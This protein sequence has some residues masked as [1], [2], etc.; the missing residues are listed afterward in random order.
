MNVIGFGL[1]K[2]PSDWSS[3]NVHELGTLKMTWGAVLAAVYT[4]APGDFAPH[5]WGEKITGKMHG[6][7]FWAAIDVRALAV[8]LGAMWPKDRGDG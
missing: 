7:V 1:R 6:Q 2:L 3:V 4:P 5:D 8:G